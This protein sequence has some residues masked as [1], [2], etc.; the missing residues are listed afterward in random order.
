MFITLVDLQSQKSEVLRDNYIHVKRIQVVLMHYLFSQLYCWMSYNEIQFLIRV[1]LLIC[2]YI[3]ENLISFLRRRVFEVFMNL[4][5][6]LIETQFKIT[7]GCLIW[8]L[9]N[10]LMRVCLLI[11]RGCVEFIIKFFYCRWFVDLTLIWSLFFRVIVDK[12][13]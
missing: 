5:F 12:F 6:Y 10:F 7:Y 3:W 13:L 9:I 11:I 1:W 8:F 4:C 2:T